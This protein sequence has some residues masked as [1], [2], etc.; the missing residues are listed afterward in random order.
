MK[1][2]ISRTREQLSKH[3]V[4]FITYLKSK[5]IWF[6]RFVLPVVLVFVVLSCSEDSLTP[7]GGNN[8]F[9]IDPNILHTDK[10]G[11]VL[12]GDTTDWCIYSP[13]TYSF[14]PAFP[15]PT[16]DT[17][18]LKFGLAQTDTVSIG[19]GKTNGDTVFLLHEQIL[20]PGMYQFSVSGRSLLLNGSTRRFYFF[21][22]KYPMGD[23][24]CRNYGD[25]QFY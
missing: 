22:R 8:Y 20:N 9:F 13:T 14:P 6:L 21:S 3:S 24:Y 16:R 25:V 23:P 10:Y 15:N 17:V 5:R 11:F 7:T 1:I 2:P 19:Y 18:F 12:G 4:Q